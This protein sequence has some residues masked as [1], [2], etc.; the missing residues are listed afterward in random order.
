MN[1]FIFKSYFFDQ[2]S[3]TASFNYAFEDGRAFTEK[4]AFKLTDNHDYNREIL[5]R[6]LFLSFMLVG[7]SYYK[8]FPSEDVLIDFPIDKWQVDFFNKVYQEGLGQFAYENG[9]KR[10]NLAHFEANAEYP[11]AMAPDYTGSGT[12]ALQSGGKDSLLTASLLKSKSIDFA[13]WYLSSGEDYPSLLESVS[14]ELIISNRLIDRN[15]LKQALGDGALNG[16][17]PITYIVQSFAVIQAILMGKSDILVSI[18]HEGEEPHHAIGDLLVSHQWSKT[19]LAEEMFASYVT[20]YI[21]PNIRIG[22]PLRCYSE[23]RVAELFVENSWKLYGDKFS[24]CNVYNYR[25][26]ANNKTLGWCGDCP[27]CA[28]SYLLFAP[29][30]PKNKLC[31][32][33]G[34]VDLFSRH[35]LTDTFKGLLGIDGFTKP[36]E[37]IGEVD[38]LRVA[39]HMA[40]KK[41]DYQKL[42]FKVPESN[43]DYK[44]LYQA[45]NWA[46][47]VLQ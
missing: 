4:V 2:A 29:F 3:K 38:E 7:V 43:F 5:D 8:T 9:L 42:P 1:R 32:L 44:Q 45:Q 28:N 15:N 36:F 46:P 39:Y 11:T 27:K 35:D 16:H 21:S 34:G 10:D 20:S 17:V 13:A 18:A 47:K 30:L 26:G 22:S 37:C 19:W 12:L 24:S 23:L 6:A 33:F 31:K 14:T 40:I 25:Q 41:Y